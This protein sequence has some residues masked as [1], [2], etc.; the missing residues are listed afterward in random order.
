[1]PLSGIEISFLYRSVHDTNHYIRAPIILGRCP[2]VSLRMRVTLSKEL[3]SSAER[4][5]QTTCGR[6]TQCTNRS[7]PV[8]STSELLLRQNSVNAHDHRLAS[9]CATENHRSESAV[10]PIHSQ[11]SVMSFTKVKGLVF[12][13]NKPEYVVGDIA[14]RHHDLPVSGW[15]AKS[16]CTSDWG[17]LTPRT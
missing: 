7:N 10:R 17:T 11:L 15:V 3:I 6:S 8:T 9:D 1:L 14:V 12:L 5:K 16:P 2:I 13:T 4:N